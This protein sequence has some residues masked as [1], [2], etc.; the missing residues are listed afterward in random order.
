MGLVL[1]MGM[2]A[3]VR[4]VRKGEMIAVP[5]GMPFWMYNDGKEPCCFLNVANIRS[6]M[7]HGGHMYEVGYC[8]PT[9]TCTCQVVL[10]VEYLSVC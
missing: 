2:K 6:P 8:L 10:T 9:H 7:M 3:N 5:R 4:Q 1:P